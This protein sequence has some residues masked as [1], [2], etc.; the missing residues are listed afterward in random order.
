[1]RALV[2]VVQRAW[3]SSDQKT[4]GE[5]TKDKKE[6]KKQIYFALSYAIETKDE[7]IKE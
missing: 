3:A 6:K 2:K 4:H 1:M 7:Y 5:D